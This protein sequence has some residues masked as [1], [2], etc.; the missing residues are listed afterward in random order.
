[1]TS[2]DKGYL[3]TLRIPRLRPWALLLLCQ[4]FCVAAAPVGLIYIGN[5]SKGSLAQGAV[6]VGAH[7]IAEAVCAA[8]MGR[9]FDRKPM[10]REFTLVLTLQAVVFLALGLFARQLPLPALAAL[11]A[12][13]GG[14][15][16][17]AHGGL[18]AL[19]L[20]LAPDHVRPVIGLESALSTL[21]W[22]AAPAAVTALSLVTGPA[23]PVLVISA[24]SAIGAV[25][26]RIVSEP[27]LT[28][29]KTPSAIRSF[30]HLLPACTQSAA[31]MMSF[32]AVTITLFGLL[33][34][35]GASADS[36]GAWLSGMAALGVLGGILYGAR[37]WPGS[38]ALQSGVL[39]GVLCIAVM[40]LG[41]SGNLIVAGFFA[42]IVGI[43]QP[44]IGSS[45]A[46]AVQDQTP[47][48]D[49]GAAFSATYAS[50][51]LGYGAAALLAG[52]LLT[53]AGPREAVLACGAIALLATVV[54]SVIEVRSLR[55]RSTAHLDPAHV[56]A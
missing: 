45:R 43:L 23:V 3:S 8:S 9:R 39:L 14:V 29:S 56:P 2:H 21:V 5:G 51:G 7:A 35:I 33:P 4:R 36:A 47:D 46:M 15:A 22:M 13:G 41:V 42:V 31:A 40:A 10:R 11:A 25:S 19:A 44:M 49:L 48:G 27:P 20:R 38:A 12:M 53:S 50:A 24:F 28:V 55:R 16:A 34:L 30:G 17:G 26:A 32:G 18:R 6:L 37:R 52:A 1:M 54:T